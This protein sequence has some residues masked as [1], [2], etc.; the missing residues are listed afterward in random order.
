MKIAELS[1]APGM[2]NCATRILSKRS[3]DVRLEVVAGDDG[4]RYQGRFQG[5]YRD[6]S[7]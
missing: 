2:V 5:N 4:Q 3:D 6:F 1:D 7:R